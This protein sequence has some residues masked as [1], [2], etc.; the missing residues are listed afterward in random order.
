MYLNTMSTSFTNIS[1]KQLFLL[2]FSVDLL[3]LPCNLVLWSTKNA[4]RWRN[5]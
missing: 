4:R 2:T 5:M 3:I 1:A